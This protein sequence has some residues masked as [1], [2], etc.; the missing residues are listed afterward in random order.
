MGACD[1]NICGMHGF[2]TRNYIC[3]SHKT[4]NG[5]KNGAFSQKCAKIFAPIVSNRR[6]KFDVENQFEGKV[7]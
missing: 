6:K 5:A 2:R 7:I 3:V 4:I 1:F